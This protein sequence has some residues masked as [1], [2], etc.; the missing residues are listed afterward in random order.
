MKIKKLMLVGAIAPLVILP[1]T[2]SAACDD[3]NKP[4]KPVT[5]ST[6]EMTAE[7]KK[8]LDAA[9]VEFKDAM[10]N[11]N[12]QLLTFS[13]ELAAKKKAIDKEKD[14]TKKEALQKERKQFVAEKSKIVAPLREEIN[15][16]LVKVNKLEAKSD[17]QTIKIFNTNDE[18]GRLVFDDGKYNN[19]SGMDTLAKFM[20]NVEHSL[21]LSAGDLIQGLPMND[22]DKG[23][24]ISLVAKEMNYDAIAIGNH[25]FDFGL[26]HMI[27]IDKQTKDKMPFLS[28]NVVYKDTMPEGVKGTRPFTPYKVV[29]LA[30]G[31]KVALIGITTPDTTI[32]SHPRNS[33]DV[34][35]KDPVTA[36]KEIVTEIENKEKINFIIALTHLG[37]GRNQVEWDSRYFADNATGVDLTIDGHSHTKVDLE[38]NK[39]SWLTQTECYTKYLSEIDLLVDKKTGKIVENLGQV[40][41]DI[42]EVEI[43]SHGKENKK[44]DELIAA[45]TKK[46]GEVNNVLA[47]KNTVHFKHIENIK[48]D[49][50]EFW[51]G[52]VEQTNLG[53]LAANAIA[54]ELAKAKKDTKDFDKYYSEDKMIGLMNGGGL[55]AD[56]PVGDVKRGDV[57]GVL[58]FGN[59]IAA[60]RVDGQTL[61][62]AIKHGASKVKSGAYPQF[63]QNVSFTIKK[64]ETIK[65]GKKVYTYEADESTIKIHD[66]EINKTETYTIVTNDFILAG[67]DGY[68]MLNFMEN[69]K[70]TTD[71]EGGDLLEVM[72]NHFKYSTDSTNF[73]E[74]KT[75]TPFAHEL[76]YYNKPEILTKIKIEG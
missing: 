30:N 41:R 61:I 4:V 71:Y 13:K 44:V 17:T 15:K 1:A 28:A 10:G 65:D 25:E 26:E 40:Q 66:K 64:T 34:I 51:R 57:L 45:L 60:V 53:V 27:N 74:G 52:R 29:T 2:I 69:K 63:S 9:R 33:K 20:Q 76:S 22:S 5:P 43:A 48:V 16:A 21:L 72:I 8:A 67:G 35:F 68:K 54:D 73:A 75:N 36:A 23:V 56:L 46:F 47:F 11:Y 62:D 3:K 19:F 58:P 55:R 49:G 14:K 70:A 50:I 18:H 37:V 7:E 32:T 24:T 12:A 38:K 59:R 6:N 39:E 42:N 31:F